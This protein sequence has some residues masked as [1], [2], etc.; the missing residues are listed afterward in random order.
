MN[1]ADLNSDDERTE[2]EL[3]AG[4]KRWCE[5]NARRMDAYFKG[6]V[7]KLLTDNEIERID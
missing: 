4:M 5:Y 6:K 1:Q 7:N 3:K 2:E